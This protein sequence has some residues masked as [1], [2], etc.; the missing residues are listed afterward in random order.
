MPPDKAYNSSIC[1][2]PTK[3]QRPLTHMAVT[4]MQNDAAAKIPPALDDSPKP[5]G[6]LEDWNDKPLETSPN[7]LSL[8]MHQSL[9]GSAHES[10]DN[11]YFPVPGAAPDVN[12]NLDVLRVFDNTPNANPG[13]IGTLSR[14][15]D[16]AFQ[17]LS[18]CQTS[19]HAFPFTLESNRPPAT[20]LAKPNPAFPWAAVRTRFTHLQ[21]VSNPLEP[22]PLVAKYADLRNAIALLDLLTNVRSP[23]PLGCQVPAL[24][25]QL[26]L[27][28][29]SFPPFR[30]LPKMFKIQPR[31][32]GPTTSLRKCYSFYQKHS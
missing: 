31:V 28:G 29:N 15:S 9:V 5:K 16:P 14:P 13:I 22:C 2:S 8:F 7:V 24:L 6:L 19:Y 3:I 21:N 30:H 18:I 10:G 23:H 32:H 11:N 26:S 25:A 12:R 17:H 27:S 1:Y 20:G 4:P